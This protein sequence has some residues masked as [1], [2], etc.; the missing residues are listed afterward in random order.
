MGNVGW[1]CDQEA[2]SM[3]STPPNCGSR[4]LVL[5]VR[6]PN[7]WDG[8]RTDS[9]DHR[10]HVVYAQNDRCPSSHPV[11]VPEIFA[12]V[13]YPSGVGGS[14]YKLADGTVTPHADFWNV[15]RQAPLEDLVR[16]CLNAGVNCGTLT[17]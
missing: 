17:G 16:R 9:A 1:S 5:H 7:C 11:K 15:W 2:S 4:L 3:V 14:G 13:R 12:H 10:S 6:F 8:V